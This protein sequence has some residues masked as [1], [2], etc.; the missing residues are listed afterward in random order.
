[1]Y[2][3][4]YPGGDEARPQP[5]IV[6]GIL[7]RLRE[8]EDVG[9]TYF[10]TDATAV[11]GQSGG[12]LV[13]EAG[14]V[15]GI[16]GFSITEGSFG[17]VASS[18][19]L[20]PRI[21]QLIAGEDPAGL[22]DR[23]LPLRGGG[24]RQHD[25]TAQSYLDA[26]IVNEPADTEVE[27]ELGGE[28]DKGVL[29]YDSFGRE[30]K[31]AG[32]GSFVTEIDGPHFLIVPEEVSG[33]ATLT[34]NHPLRR[35]VDPDRDRPI[36]AG[37]SL[38]GNIDFPGDID[39][40]VL[41]LEKDEKVT[42]V[43]R[44]VLADTML[45]VSHTGATEEQQVTDDDSGGG[46]FRQDAGVEYK[47]SHTGKYT[48]I[49]ESTSGRAPGGYAISVDSDRTRRAATPL[50]PKLWIKRLVEV[51]QGPGV[52]YPISG[53]VVTGEQY[54]ITGKDAAG[55][56]WQIEYDGQIGWVAAEMMTATNAEDVEVV[57][58]LLA[59]RSVPVVS[60]H[61][62]LVF[63]IGDTP[64]VSGGA[65]EGWLAYEDG[66]HG[67]K[68]FYP[69]NWLFASSKEE[70]PSLL[71]QM[72]D[73]SIAEAVVNAQAT[74]IDSLTPTGE[75][76]RFVGMGFP[77]DPEASRG[78]VNAFDILAVPAEGRTLEAFA[79]LLSDRLE[80]S[81]S[82]TVERIDVGPGLRPWGEQVASI[83]Y[84]S[85]GVLVLGDT[86]VTAPGG[87][88]VGWKVALHSPDGET[89]L[90]VTF[91]VWGEDFAGLEPLLRGIVRQVEWVNQP[92]Y[93]PPAGPTITI[94]RTM[95]IRGGPGT[96]YA[97]VGSGAAGQQ[98]AAITMN[99]AG[100]WWQIV[101]EGQLAWVYAPFVTQSEDS[102]GRAKV[103]ASGWQT[104]ED[105]AAGLALSYPSG[106]H[107]LDPAQP[108]QAD[109]TL[110]SAA[111]EGDG[112]QLGV[113]EAADL[114][115]AMSVRREDAVIGLGLQTV[116]PDA[117]DTP[118]NFMLVYAF[119][120]DG[121]TLDSYAQMAADLLQR[122]FGVEADS[123]ELTRGLRPL[124]DE[125]VSIRYRE[126][127]TDCEVWQ[128]WL[129][130]P[131]AE[132]LLAVVFSVQSNEFS[133][134]EPLLSEIV[135]RVQ[136]TGQPKGA[137]ATSQRKLN[138]HSGP[139]T[140]YPVIGTAE[141]DLQFRIAGKDSDESWW[142]IEFEGQRGWIFGESVTTADDE[143]VPVA[144]DIPPP[145]PPPTDP[146]LTIDRNMNVRAGPGTFYPVLVTAN[147]GDKYF[148]TGQNRSGSWWRIN[149][150]EESGWVFAQ[151]AT[152]D[153]P[154]EDVPVVESFDW[155]AYYDSN[156]RLWI[157]Y[158]PGWFFFNPAH[159]SDADRRSLFDLLGRERAEDM[160]S[161]FAAEIDSE[162]RETLVGFG[163]KAVSD[164]S[165]QM[166]ASAFPSEGL[167]LRRVMSIIT[168]S[169]RGSGFDVD[170][171]EV[172]TNLR[173]DGSETGSIRYRDNREGL[174]SEDIYWQV[175]VLSPDR[176]TLIRITFIYENA[177]AS[178]SVPL[179]SEMVRRIRWE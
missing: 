7:S 80:E 142:Q 120:A 58:G 121:L 95:N 124:G 160:L 60:V 71:S 31:G 117:D 38:H 49:V 108:S 155:D 139:G 73:Q 22:G 13:S 33:E 21:R 106:W 48:L 15:I 119:A 93:E 171:S 70:L 122:R 19:D 18:A 50:A 128:V 133:E 174:G 25:L 62:P 168:E 125:A 26:Y 99:A 29:V 44:S 75:E 137:V 157:F 115:S 32:R 153:G 10:Q 154:L 68:V 169:M 163:F 132:K 177:G 42:I 145:P 159:P 158:P 57:F 76:D 118:G 63:P 92:A 61:N 81:G 100:D 16:S 131:D 54:M 147:P 94:S 77:F 111:K 91:D 161:D 23:R 30:P 64:A 52:K 2:L 123:V 178:Q 27:F 40:Y 149:F 126:D 3:I 97:I 140:E 107:F 8:W 148:I 43:V 90:V 170:S 69:P 105:D 37:E 45:T 127:V 86:A 114:L 5:A 165:N 72:G 39:T 65:F 47:A 89:F 109:L 172:V 46:L 53:A 141:A 6:R 51:R 56:W 135:Q 179:M 88:V 59:T 150:N 17:L 143:N 156:R 55:D 167:D 85:G 152:A 82:A 144:T 78:Y 134:L 173:Y 28:S 67:L 20:L 36:E 136:W 34:A 11:G 130:S 101:Y 84:R 146:V 9:V 164:Y 66:T 102:A 41:Q 116:L 87:E 129:L 103:D 113:A 12:A 83:R 74:Y 98:F 110:L 166:F 104:Y 14:D 138:V 79:Q 96:N 24:K 112:E 175:W 35:F 151:L 4:G 1:M 176:G 162:E